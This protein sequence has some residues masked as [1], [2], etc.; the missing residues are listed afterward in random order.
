MTSR[1]LE[2]PSRAQASAHSARR[3]LYPDETFAWCSPE[4]S[5]TSRHPSSSSATGRTSSERKSIRS[6]WSASPNSDEIWSSSPVCAPTQS[7]SIR[8]HIIA[9]S[10]RSGRRTPLTANS[11]STRATS[12]A[13]DDDRPAPRGTVPGDLER[14][15][16]ERHA[17]AEQLAGGPADEPAPA[18]RR[19]HGGER[20]AVALAQIGRRRV[21]P[22]RIE[23][24]RT[25]GHPFA[26]RERQREP[27]VV[28]GVL[29]DQVG[30]TGSEG[31]G[32]AGQGSIS[33]LAMR[34]KWGIVSTAHINR[35]FLAGARESPAVEILA[36]AS[37]DQGRAE[38][39][40]RRQ[41]HRARVRQLRRA[42]E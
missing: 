34:V 37:R 2:T 11:A 19:L 4:S 25:D 29:A 31:D 41:R 1:K 9:R 24:R 8:E 7:F 3:S 20:E 14:R 12:S 32:V 39:Y 30:A 15:P 6:A 5:V 13:A 38:Q 18:T 23:R 16:T 36:V 42:T 27:L 40:A 21:D 22:R 26:D 35:L 33:V 17:G 28:V 10:R